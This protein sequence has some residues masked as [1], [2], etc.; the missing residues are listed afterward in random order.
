[1]RKRHNK[2]PGYIAERMNPYVPGTKVV[3]YRACEQRLCNSGGKYAVVCDAHGTIDNTTN[4]PWA[5]KLM[6]LPDE[7]C[8]GCRAIKEGTTDATA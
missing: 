4:I 2:E 8:L 5:R 1:M 7:F 6:R 3:I